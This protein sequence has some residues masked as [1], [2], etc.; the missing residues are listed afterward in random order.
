MLFRSGSSALASISDDGRYV[1]W[2]S[3]A[4]DLVPGDD[5]GAMDVFVRDRQL[6]TTERVS[7]GPDGKAADGIS[8]DDLYR[9]CR[10]VA[11]E[12][13]IAGEYRRRARSHPPRRSTMWSSRWRGTRRWTHV[14][15]RSW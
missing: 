10:R 15:A 13:G 12:H 3:T 11:D 6:G 14:P 5:N 8:Y 7:V 4:S 1:S 2:A 9:R